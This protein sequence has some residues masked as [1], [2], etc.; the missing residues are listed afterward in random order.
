[1]KDD[2]DSIIKLFAFAFVFGMYMMFMLFWALGYYTVKAGVIGMTIG[3][4]VCALITLIPSK[5]DKRKR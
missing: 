1:M 2:D 3:I 4:I 5:H